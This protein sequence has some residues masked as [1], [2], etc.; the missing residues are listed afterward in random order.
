M[1][2]RRRRL[3]CR[4][5]HMREAKQGETKAQVWEAQVP[6]FYL[7][8]SRRP[9][10]DADM[11][12]PMHPLGSSAS[13]DWHR[14]TPPRTPPSD[15][16]RVNRLAGQANVDTAQIESLLTIVLNSGVALVSNSPGMERLNLWRRISAA[17]RTCQGR[18][19][20]CH[21]RQGFAM[22]NPFHKEPTELPYTLHHRQLFPGANDIE[23]YVLVSEEGWK[24]LYKNAF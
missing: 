8:P 16:P 3:A 7:T 2:D 6:G 13:T 1:S 20:T 17:G 24:R 18:N 11:T 9:D 15:E 21:I 19:L 4:N 22:V 14:T 12:S 10:G 23:I 5:N